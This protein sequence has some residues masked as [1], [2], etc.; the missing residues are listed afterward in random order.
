MSVTKYEI[1]AI[2]NFNGIMP[3]APP[4]Y[5]KKTAKQ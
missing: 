4:I 5:E 2:H 1:S 3:K